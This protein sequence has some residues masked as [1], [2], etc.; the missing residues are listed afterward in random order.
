MPRTISKHI[1]IDEELWK[2]LE[3]AARE[4][5]V[6]RQPPS[7]R[8]RQAVAGEQG[9]AAIGGAG[10]RRARLA[11]YG[12]SCCARHDR[13]RPQDRGRPNPRAR[14]R[15]RSRRHSRTIGGGRGGLAETRFK[16]TRFVKLAGRQPARQ[17]ARC[18]LAYGVMNSVVV[19]PDFP[20]ASL[21]VVE[22]LGS[23]RLSSRR[24]TYGAC[25]VPG[26]KGD[27]ATC[28]PSHKRLPFDVGGGACLSPHRRR[29]AR[30]PHARAGFDVGSCSAIQ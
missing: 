9:V 29:C 5:D 30:R 24:A 21:H 6:S 7:R 16:P 22:S 25:A 13:R 2:R 4:E 27:Y 23:R 15:H 20:K 1:R 12:A 26:R 3:A 10:P 28:R 11:L 14:G 18:C 19:P 17:Q 8:A